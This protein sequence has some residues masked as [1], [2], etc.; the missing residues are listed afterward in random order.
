[1]AQFFA[2]Y[3]ALQMLAACDKHEF[4]EAKVNKNAHLDGLDFMLYVV[5][6]VTEY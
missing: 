1:M 6:I 5:L 2:S 4:K 3:F